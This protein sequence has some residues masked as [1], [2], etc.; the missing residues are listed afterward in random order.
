MGERQGGL[1][2]IVLA[3]AALPLAASATEGGGGHYPNGAEGFYA[4]AVPPPG[5]YF[6]NYLVNYHADRLNDGN[7]DNMIPGFKLDVWAETLRFLQI[8][9]HELWGGNWGWH[10]FVPILH[11]DVD[12]P[13]VPESKKGMLGDLIVSPFVVAWHHSKNLHSVA[14][15]DVYMPTGA[16]DKNRLANPGRNYWT[17]EPVYAATYITDDGWEASG[18]FMYDFNG[19]NNDT[20][21]RSGQEFHVDYTFAKH[22]GSWAVGVG[23]YYYHQTTDDSGGGAPPD[24][25]KGKAFAVGPQV[26]FDVGKVKAILKYQ[27]ETDTENRPQGN[28]FWFKLIVPL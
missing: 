15:V 3:L 28:N 17:V 21:Y 26:M 2:A 24:G 11:V 18:K 13:N 5:N 12:I 16:Y 1:K 23:G 8:T 19:R 7:G 6:I 22:F 14:A 10:V 25:F 4:G 27:W 20:D 9:K